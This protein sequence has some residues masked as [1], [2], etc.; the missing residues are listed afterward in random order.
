MTT[1]Q[2]SNPDELRK[3]YES[4]DSEEL[5]TRFKTRSLEPEAEKIAKEILENRGICLKESD[6]ETT[7]A[8]E[9]SFSIRAEEE[10]LA[11]NF[12]LWIA[13]RIGVKQV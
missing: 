7:S 5:R 12:C 1:S 11:P 4:L 13:I 8:G 3:L 2:N 6:R 9:W 10:R